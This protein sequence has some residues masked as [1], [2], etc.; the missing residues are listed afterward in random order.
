[1]KGYR[2]AVFL[3]IF[4]LLYGL[5]NLYI[6]SGAFNALQ[7]FLPALWQHVFTGVF[8]FMVL[9]YPVGRIFGKWLPAKLADFLAFAGGLWFAAMLYLI[10]SLII[11]DALAL[12]ISFVPSIEKLIDAI[13]PEINSGI[14]L[15]IST[16]VIGLI[17]FGYFNATSIRIKKLKLKVAKSPP[18]L[19]SLHIAF[20]SDIHLGHVIG[21]KS[22]GKIISAINSLDPDLVL[23]PGDLVDEELKTV[24]DKGLGKK[25]MQL[26]P[27]YGVFAV[28]GNH[29]YISGAD[30][31]VAYLSQFGIRFLR[32]EMIKVADRFYVA[33]RED[34]SITSFYGR[35]R[36]TAQELLNGYNPDI[37]VILM[38]HQPISLAEAAAAGVD[39]QVSGHTHHGQMWPLS[40]IT[41]RVFKLSWGYRKIGSSH[42]Y[43]SS[44]AG[45]WGPR[46][47]IGNHP[48]IVSIKLNFAGQPKVRQSNKP[49]I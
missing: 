22:L 42:F 47:R 19:E 12:V 40:A 20:A 24:I 45:S 4:F 25:F 11:V 39:L 21:S 34:V 30:K 46:V 8:L 2:L 49:K 6:F 33:G 17:V 43:V 32:D 35:K 31:A 16:G 23:F 44:G 41:K 1:M 14:F 15:L 10:I 5:L 13:Q 9:S 28:T 26:K 29:E 27:K 37:P 3:T 38:D 7:Y 48:E 36:K 18:G